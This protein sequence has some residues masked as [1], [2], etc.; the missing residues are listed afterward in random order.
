[1]MA[2]VDYVANGIGIDAFRILDTRHFPM[3]R[4]CELCGAFTLL[5]R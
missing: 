1:M 4:S 5:L 2:T 3:E